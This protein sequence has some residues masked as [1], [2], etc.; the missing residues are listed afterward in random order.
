MT[1]A[2]SYHRYAYEPASDDDQVLW[3]SKGNVLRGTSPPMIAAFARLVAPLF[4]SLSCSCTGW[5]ESLCD[6]SCTRAGHEM[7]D[8]VNV[9]TDEATVF[10]LHSSAYNDPPHPPAATTLDLP[11]GRWALR[12][13]DIVGGVVLEAT[14]TVDAGGGGGK[15]VQFTTAMLTSLPLT[16]NATA[17]PCHDGKSGGEDSC[18]SADATACTP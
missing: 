3:W 4:D 14:V 11:G 1:D 7:G 5:G 16:N 13:V 8:G 12:P 10:L 6:D 18:C 2:H 9:A 17:S 15:P